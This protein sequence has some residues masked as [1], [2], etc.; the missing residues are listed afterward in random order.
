MQRHIAPCAIMSCRRHEA[1]LVTKYLSNLI[2]QDHRGVKPRIGPGLGLEWLRTAVVTIVG[3]ELLRRIHKGQ[4]NLGRLRLKDRRTRPVWNAAH[5]R[6][7]WLTTAQ[8]HPA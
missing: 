6:L 2:E 5:D 1:A 4:F 7:A 8:A 3:I